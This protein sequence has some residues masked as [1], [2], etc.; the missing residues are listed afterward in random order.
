MELKNLT[1]KQA[2]EILYL[3]YPFHDGIK[4]EIKHKYSP[5][6]EEY[7][8]PEYYS[9]HFDGIIFGDKI[10]K[11]RVFIYSNLDCEIDYTRNNLPQGRLPVRNQK[12]IQEKFKEFGF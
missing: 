1:E 10:D 8:E 6:E 9:M 5:L 2:N 4:S 11:I 12:L 7:N 3:I